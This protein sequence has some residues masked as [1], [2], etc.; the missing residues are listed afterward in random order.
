LNEQKLAKEE[1]IRKLLEEKQKLLSDNDA[2]KKMADME[3][4]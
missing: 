4:Q 2:S 3:D 1:E